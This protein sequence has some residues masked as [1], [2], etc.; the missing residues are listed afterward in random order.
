M[1]CTGVSSLSGQRVVATGCVHLAGVHIV[2][3]ELARLV[4]RHGATF[5][6]EF[7]AETTL[8]VMGEWRPH[9]VQDD[10]QGGVDAIEQVALGRQRGA[11]HVHLV[12]HDDLHDL[13]EGALVPCRRIP[14][15]WIAM[16]KTSR[17]SAVRQRP[18]E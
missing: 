12:R 1:A 13:I 17:R 6:P 4:K 14:Q 16:K 3:H 10:R 18:Y 9:Q 7:S 2:R 15:S 8:V 5:H 11:P